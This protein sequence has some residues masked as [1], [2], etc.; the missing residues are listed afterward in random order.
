MALAHYA[1]TR[2]FSAQW[3]IDPSALR[4]VAIR[5]GFAPFTASIAAHSSFEW[6]V[7]VAKF[8]PVTGALRQI[9]FSGFDF[10]GT[11]PFSATLAVDCADPALE[12]STKAAAI[13]N[14]IVQIRMS[15]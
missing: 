10:T 9:G 12:L 14:F 4:A 13:R 15:V 6:Q 11:M 5:S 7:R 8:E 2:A 1:T 3:V